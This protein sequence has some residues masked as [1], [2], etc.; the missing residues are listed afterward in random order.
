MNNPETDTFTI[1]RINNDDIHCIAVE[2]PQLSGLDEI[3]G[4]SG[5]IETSHK[6]NLDSDA[7]DRT[8]YQFGTGNRTVLDRNVAVIC[9]GIGG[10]VAHCATDRIK[11][12]WCSETD[13]EQLKSAGLE[14]NV[15]TDKHGSSVSYDLM[16]DG[17]PT[18]SGVIKQIRE[19]LKGRLVLVDPPEEP[20]ITKPKHSLLA[21][22]GQATTKLATTF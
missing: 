13:L 7:P 1:R 10:R 18:G 17:F 2:Y 16:Q 22:V 12:S 20:K 21:R 8:E 5:V 15:E 9:S 6:L 3:A 4:L 11:L 19:C 14:G